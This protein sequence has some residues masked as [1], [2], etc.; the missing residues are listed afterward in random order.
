MN[1][2][3]P[4]KKVRL[5]SVVYRRPKHSAEAEVIS[6]SASASVAEGILR[7]YGRIHVRIHY[8]KIWAPRAPKIN[9][10]K[11]TWLIVRYIKG[12]PPYFS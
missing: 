8:K 10:F 11:L 3:I 1:V 12:F 2:I 4:A 6:T 9:A 5:G 7:V